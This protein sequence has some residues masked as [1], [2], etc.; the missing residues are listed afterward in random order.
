MKIEEAIDQLE[1]INKEMHIYSEAV[2]VAIHALENMI[3]MKPIA[4]VD[5]WLCPT[6]RNPVE[7]QSMIGPNILCQETYDFCPK[8]GQA[9][10]WEGE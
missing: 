7:H 6:C 8:C 10:D 2:E 1:E 9:I 3:P 4:P 5:T